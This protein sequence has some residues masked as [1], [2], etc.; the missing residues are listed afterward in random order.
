M[1]AAQRRRLEQL[2]A[3][4]AAIPHNG[5]PESALRPCELP[6]IARRVRTGESGPVPA[7]LNMTAALTPVTSSAGQE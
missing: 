6:E 7:E 2:R 5:Q 4:I 1:T 3:H